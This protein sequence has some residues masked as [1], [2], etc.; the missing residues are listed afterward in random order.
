[1]VHAQGSGVVSS[2][3][4][5]E[6]Q[7]LEPYGNPGLHKTYLSAAYPYGMTEEKKA[8]PVTAYVLAR[9]ADMD[10]THGL[11]AEALRRGGL[12][13]NAASILRT[14]ASGVGAKR[15]PM[16]AKALGFRDVEALRTAAF[17]YAQERTERP[18]TDAHREAIAHARA[19][20]QLTD[21]EAERIIRGAFQ[22]WDRPAEWWLSHILA[23]YKYVR[24]LR[25]AE[26]RA[27]AEEAAYRASV[28]AQKRRLST[29]P[30][31]TPPAA[32][33]A[34]LPVRRRKTA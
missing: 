7:F 24:T 32:P 21:A 30:D 3:M 27:E 28:R 23:E 33:A 20:G 10:A 29:P 17:V 13:R 5:G 22:Y 16:W 19:L 25:E 11:V 26:A 2:V 1:M 18:L 31:T 12:A 9:V 6:L 4:S 14:G 8:D 34:A 15:E